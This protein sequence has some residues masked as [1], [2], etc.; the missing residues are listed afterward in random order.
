RAARSSARTNVAGWSCAASP[1]C[2]LGMRHSGARDRRIHAVGGNRHSELATAPPTYRGR[3]IWSVWTG[4]SRCRHAGRR[5]AFPDQPQRNLSTASIPSSWHLA[6]NRRYVPIGGDSLSLRRA[7]AVELLEP[8]G[9]TR[10][11]F[12]RRRQ[13]QLSKDK[14]DA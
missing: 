3:L 1:R 7:V 8:A 10:P 11:F 13:R 2:R 4:S 14:S 6:T 9:H 12:E 5:L